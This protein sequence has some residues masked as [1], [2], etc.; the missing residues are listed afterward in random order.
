MA[1]RVE[2]LLRVGL[3][4]FFFSCVYFNSS[5]ASGRDYSFLIDDSLIRRLSDLFKVSR[6]ASGCVRLVLAG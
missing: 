6:S 4:S 2:C 3:R 1:S 5:V